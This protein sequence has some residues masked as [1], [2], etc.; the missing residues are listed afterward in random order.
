[1]HTSKVE[2]AAAGRP[3]GL[4]RRGTTTASVLERAGRWG[5]GSKR[6]AFEALSLSLELQQSMEELSRRRRPSDSPEPH[7]IDPIRLPSARSMPALP[8]PT[9][10]CIELPPPPPRVARITRLQIPICL[11]SA[12]VFFLPWI[13]GAMYRGGARNVW[14]GRVFVRLRK[15]LNAILA[16][17]WYNFNG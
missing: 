5:P 12:C 17:G 6:R 16:G 9:P 1:M 14:F 10:P 3:G 13:N 4:R 2:T 8:E 15:L 11:T 7:V